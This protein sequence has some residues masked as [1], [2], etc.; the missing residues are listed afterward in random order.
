MVGKTSI[1]GDV[2]TKQKGRRRV[3]VKI[4]KYMAQRWRQE[5]IVLP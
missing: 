1:L 3:A 4:V 2:E 5:H